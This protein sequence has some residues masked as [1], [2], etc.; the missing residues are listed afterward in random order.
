M[1]SFPRVGSKSKEIPRS[2][3]LRHERKM[4]MLALAELYCSF[5]RNIS[6]AKLQIS[7]VVPP[8]SSST[9]P[10]KHKPHGYSAGDAASGL[11]DFPD[12]QARDYHQLC[13]HSTAELEHSGDFCSRKWSDLSDLDLKSKVPQHGIDWHEAFEVLD[14]QQCMTFGV[15]HG[16]LQRVHN[17]PLAIEEKH[18]RINSKTSQMNEPTLLSMG[19]FVHGCW[20]LS[21]HA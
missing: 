10:Y 1:S 4:M 6:F 14:H 9:A 5:H 12:S 13:H 7:K 11:V 17:F 15:M 21:Q 16:L 3:S 20:V 8:L 19:G 2:L 18:V